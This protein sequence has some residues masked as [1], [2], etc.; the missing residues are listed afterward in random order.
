MKKS[1]LAA[2]CMLAFAAVAEFVSV[3]LSD[4][5]TSVPAGKVVSIS[6][7][8]TNASGTATFKRVTPLTFSWSETV[9][10]VVTN[11]SVSINGITN[12]SVRIIRSTNPRSFY[13]PITNNV[14]SLAISDGRATTNLTG[15]VS[16][17]GDRILSSGV[18][19]RAVIVLER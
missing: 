7:V 15:V 17:P 19:G 16:L 13:A 10:T 14:C 8:S 9:E 5:I 18:L 11:T 4:G 12:N 1:I 3:D 2:S 6:A